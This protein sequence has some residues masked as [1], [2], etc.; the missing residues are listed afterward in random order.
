[1]FIHPLANRSV[2]S[3]KLNVHRNSGNKTA[4]QNNY[5]FYDFTTY[6]LDFIAVGRRNNITNNSLSFWQC[7][8]LKLQVSL[9]F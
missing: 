3:Y 4:V 7:F 8:S 5:T 9:F 2:S 1:M 6:Y